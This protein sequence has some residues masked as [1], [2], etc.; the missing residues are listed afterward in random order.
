MLGPV[1]K[2]DSNVRL[3]MKKIFVAFA[4]DIAP[5]ILDKMAVAQQKPSAAN[6]PPSLRCQVRNER[7]RPATAPMSGYGELQLQSEQQASEGSGRYPDHRAAERQP[8][9][10]RS[11]DVEQ[12]L[13]HQTSLIV[14]GGV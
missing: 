13:A 6:T 9:A 14:V 10:H 8:L 12:G 4:L 3:V 2:S 1:S 11:L 7:L 5:A